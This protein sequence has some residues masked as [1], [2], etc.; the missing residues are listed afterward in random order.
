MA[1]PDSSSEVVAVAL[2]LARD[3]CNL[4]QERPSGVGVGVLLWQLLPFSRSQHLQQPLWLL[5]EVLPSVSWRVYWCFVWKC[6]S[7]V[8]KKDCHWQSPV[9]Y[10]VKNA[11]RVLLVGLPASRLWLI[12]IAQYVTNSINY[13]IWKTYLFTFLW[14]PATKFI[15]E[16]YGGAF[17][18]DIPFWRSTTSLSEVPYVSLP[19][20]CTLSLDTFRDLGRW[21]FRASLALSQGGVRLTPRLISAEVLCLFIFRCASRGTVGK[22]TCVD[23]SI[24][25]SSWER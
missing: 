4:R 23:W 20:E 10:V 9:K 1:K 15:V 11:S 6:Y 12:K 17:S 5:A 22:F 14:F 24:S 16:L 7:Y 2:S 3:I 21:E 18:L 19:F 8:Q 13:L 25:M